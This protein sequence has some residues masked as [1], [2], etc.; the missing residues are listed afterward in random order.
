MDFMMADIFREPGKSKTF[1]YWFNVNF[2]HIA[3]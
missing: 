2:G 3:P 1:Y